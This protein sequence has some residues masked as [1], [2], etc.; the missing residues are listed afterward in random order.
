[1]SPGD[2]TARALRHDLPCRLREPLGEA[3]QGTTSAETVSGFLRET[4]L[5]PAC[6]HLEITETAAMSDATAS[7]PALEN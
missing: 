4:D 1:V 7:A 5:D 3:V 2:R 6:L